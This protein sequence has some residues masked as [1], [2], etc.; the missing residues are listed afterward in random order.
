MTTTRKRIIRTLVVIGI[1]LAILVTMHVLV[2]SLNLPG[3]LRSMHG[4]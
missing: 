1:I 3:I 2:N 4:G